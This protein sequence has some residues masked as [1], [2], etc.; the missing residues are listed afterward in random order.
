MDFGNVYP[1]EQE[2]GEEKIDLI[3]NFTHVMVFFSTL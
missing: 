3:N 1:E 2:S